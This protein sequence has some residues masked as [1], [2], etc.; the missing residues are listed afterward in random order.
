MPGTRQRRL[1][2]HSQ[3]VMH[4][5]VQAM[6]V[7]T[8]LFA[9][10]H[11]LIVGGALIV[12]N[13]I[14]INRRYRRPPPNSENR[15]RTLGQCFARFNDTECERLFRFNH[16]GLVELVRVLGV[17]PTVSIQKNNARA[18]GGTETMINT[19]REELILI[20]LRRMA[21]AS[22]WCDLEKELGLPEAVLSDC[23]EWVIQF[24]HTRCVGPTPHTK[25]ETAARIRPSHTMLGFRGKNTMPCR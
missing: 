21:Y 7:M 4:A 5:M 24:L 16:D 15:M 23:F 2:R 6:A 13:M 25:N 10:R 18:P 17:P 22:R 14:E 19:T 1:R 9:D 12:N 8:F 3:H 11:D 20:M